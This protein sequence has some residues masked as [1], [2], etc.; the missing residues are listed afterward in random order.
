[1]TVRL[2]NSL[3]FTSEKFNGFG[4][5]G[6]V[7]LNNK[8]TTQ[9]SSTEG[10]NNNSYGYGLAADYTWNKLYTILSY[11]SFTNSQIGTL[12]SP[13]PAIWSS[14]SGG[15]NTTDNQFFVGS[16]YN[17]GKIKGFAQYIDRKATSV[18]DSSY[19]TS[20]TAQ[21]IGVRSFITP[22]VEGWA[23]VGNGKVT[24]FGTGGTTVNFVGFQFG[25]NYWLSKRTNLY[26]ILGQNKTTSESGITPLS[27]SSYAAGIR[28]TF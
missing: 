23:S 19:S 28:H 3:T 22:K 20:R 14:A 2:S 26:A 21:Q 16:T 11:Q 10:G 18:I 9:T 27:A 13:T 6:M 24:A 15:T 5:N 8:N 7:V 17:F 25:S 12:T 4:V 1:M